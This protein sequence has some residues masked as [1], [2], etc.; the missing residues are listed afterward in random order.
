MRP[1]VAGPRR[2]SGVLLYAVLVVA[3]LMAASC[4]NA[5][6]AKGPARNG[7]ATAASNP[8]DLAALKRQA[9]IE[10]CPRTS[11]KVETIDD[12]LPDIT[13]TC[14]GGGRAVDLAGLR[15]RP[16]VVNLWAHWCGPCRSEVPL[17][18]RLHEQAGARL[19][20]I[21]IDF[22]DPQ[23]G[24][25]I[26]F[27][28]ALGMS[29]PQLADPDTLLKAPV[30]VPGLPVTLFVAPDGTIAGRQIGPVD[31]YDQLTQLVSDNLGVSL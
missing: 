19:R 28:E 8:Q 18:Q 10:P 31:T 17:F 13:L 14:L 21:G 11:A 6:Q 7:D 15:G 24:E 5:D 4:S 27:A 9:G 20:V 16:T 25:A 23:A 29:Y 2:V 1:A 26:A 22:D 3:A 30:G 12:G